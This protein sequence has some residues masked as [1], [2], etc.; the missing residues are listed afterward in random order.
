MTKFDEAKKTL[1]EVFGYDDFRGGQDVMVRRILDGESV[2]GVFP[3][4]TGKSI[5]YQLPAIMSKKLTIIVSPL[6]ALMQ[7]QVDGLN[8]KGVKSIAFNSTMTE[9]SKRKA[10]IDLIQSDCKIVFVAPERFDD[11]SFMKVVSLL[12]I[13]YFVVDEA[14]CISQWGHNFRPDYTRLGD[15]VKKLGNPQVIALTATA[16]PSTQEEIIEMLNLHKDPVIGGFTR[17]NLS[18]KVVNSFTAYKKRG[19]DIASLLS[20]YYE[21]GEGTAIVYCST[22]AQVDALT[23]SLVAAGYNVG[24]YYANELTNKERNE[25]QTRFMD[26][27][28]DVL[29]CTNAFGMG[30]DKSDVRVII[31]G[32]ISGSL[33]AYYQEA[34]RAGRD[35]KESVCI[36]TYNP[37]DYGVQK[38][39][40]D[41]AY[42]FPGTIQAVWDYIKEHV[43]KAY[44][45][46]SGKYFRKS[47]EGEEYLY[48]TTTEHE[49]YFPA[50]SM[51][52]V[53]AIAS[54]K[55]GDF[56][57]DPVVEACLRNLKRAG[58][59]TYS[60]A[61]KQMELR[62]D[63]RKIEDEELD[64]DWEY[65]EL[66]RRIAF[67]LLNEMN[68]YAQSGSVCRQGRVLNYFSPKSPAYKCGKCD[69][70]KTNNWGQTPT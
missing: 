16:T 62:V 37:K 63:T 9:K 19:P 15:V 12:D 21:P 64:I 52:E 1:K 58:Y 40:I 61:K 66:R 57:V 3:T 48:V 25:V 17:P 2:L 20:R 30:I 8:A 34:G 50:L 26:G 13:E 56:V 31:H 59:L 6:I 14:H 68:N 18:F 10:L 45:E 5:I 41:C 36:L 27:E 32:C 49:A 55:T 69:V 33:E 11:D 70:C 65:I 23:E 22:R 60:N 53:G 47:K 51:G 35:G 54:K 67:S 39:F 44:E 43:V 7:D 42:P 46:S 38:F 4:G 28:I 29:V 24:F